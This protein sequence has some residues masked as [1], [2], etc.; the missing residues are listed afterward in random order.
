MSF[1]NNNAA[2]PQL[3]ISRTSRCPQTQQSSQNSYHLRFLY[4]S[5]S[6]LAF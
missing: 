4:L 2:P 1:N 5:A 3:R 6:F